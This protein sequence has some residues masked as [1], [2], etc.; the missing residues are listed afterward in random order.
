MILEPNICK[1][2][3][4][5]EVYNILGFKKFYLYDYLNEP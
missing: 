1:K 5:I 4:Y 2:V 3:Q